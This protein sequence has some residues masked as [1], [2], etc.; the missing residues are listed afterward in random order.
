MYE[1]RPY[2]AQALENLRNEVRRGNKR[3]L[4][5]S[6]TGCHAKGQ[7]ILMF[8]GSVRLVEEVDTGDLLMGPDS[9]PRQVTRL[10]RGFGDMYRI[11]P[12]KGKPF[13]INSEHILTLIHTVSGNLTDISVND[14]LSWNITKKHTHK[15]LRCQVEFAERKNLII[16]PYFLG[17]L[18]GDGCLTHGAAV[19]KPGQFILEEMNHQAEMHGLKVRT[20]WRSENNS[21][22]FITKGY[23]GNGENQLLQKLRSIGIS[24]CKSGD[25][26]I[27]EEYKTASFH[28]RMDVLAGLLDT[29][30]HLSTGVFY[31][32]SKSKQLANDVVF[33][34]RSVG[35]AA[36]ISECEKGCQTGAAG[37]Y[38]RV[39][40]SGNCSFIPCR[41]NRAEPRRQKKDVLRTGFTIDPVGHGPYYGFTL[42]GDGRYLMDDFTVTHNSGK[43][44]IAS[45]L[46]DS[47]VIKRSRVVFIA[48]RKEIIDQT[49][50]KLRSMDI[51]HGIIMSGH[52][53]SA[54]AEVF[55]A[56]IQTLVRRELPQADLIILD[57]SHHGPCNSFQKIIEAYPNA[58]I[59]G[60]TATPCRGDGR[61]LGNIFNSIV[62]VA[63]TYELISQGYLV[64][65]IV[66]APSKPDLGGVHI[67]RGDYDAAELENAVDRPKLVGDIVDHWHKLAHGRQTIV[68]ATG[69]PHS[70][71]L[72]EAF[73][74]SGETC[75]HIDGETPKRQREEILGRLI[76]C[77]TRIV[78]NVGVLTEG[79]DAP[80]VSCIVLARPTK[81]FGLYLQMAGRGLRPSPGKE[82]LLLLDHAGAVYEHGMVDQH[83]DWTMDEKEK[84]FRKKEYEKKTLMPWTCG[85]CFRINEPSK[86]K[87]CVGCGFMKTRTDSSPAI[88][89][90]SLKKI[91]KAERRYKSK[92][93]KQKYW[94]ECAFKARHLGLNIGAAAHMYKKQIGVWPRGLERVPRGNQWQMSAQ[95][96]LANDR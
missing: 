6:P 83:I 76:S 85:H 67:R 95:E 88:G 53:P 90:G 70:L 18:L 45:H 81:S 30:G 26:F 54:L 64:P 23:K 47:A 80:S 29:D 57:E 74:N 89:E 28:D 46:I 84:A 94:I 65:T 59:I 86:D 75:E 68:F 2:Q 27:P 60:L 38:Y 19:A 17:L 62:Q 39:C 42:G 93:D 1:L 9:T 51:E 52:A 20:A 33:V 61:G 10:C 58:V 44:V 82:N 8:D 7:G 71:H 4:L 91:E 55:V 73:R 63:Q 32:I 77:E 78:C 43:T 3:P 41:R 87:H 14:Y 69:I 31:Y 25:K 48:H 36:Y 40:I 37:T 96:F 22:H 5:V 11:K 56:S 79:F 34:A 13:I 24:G 21:T 35:L 49:S 92:E 72:V 50:E 15:L 16:E 12:V 66:Y